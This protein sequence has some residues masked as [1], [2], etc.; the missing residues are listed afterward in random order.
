M[1][2]YHNLTAGLITSCW[3]SFINHQTWLSSCGQST[4]KISFF[5]FP[6]QH[7]LMMNPVSA[8]KMVMLL[9]EAYPARPKVDSSSWKKSCKTVQTFFLPSQVPLPTCSSI[10]IRVS[11]VTWP[12]FLCWESWEE[13]KT[14]YFEV[15]IWK[16]VSQGIYDLI[17]ISLKCICHIR[18]STISNI[19][20]Y[21]ALCKL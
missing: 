4:S 12:I 10:Q 14:I 20:F 16:W 8:K 19:H 1:W 15:I 3:L 13:K 5:H 7:A 11:W 21:S 6:S 2:I 9:Q 18:G 17:F